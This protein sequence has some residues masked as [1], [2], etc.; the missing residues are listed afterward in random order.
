MDYPKLRL[1]EAF[2][3]Q[4]N[5]ICLRDTES[6]SDKIL[7]VP[8]NIFFI[9]TLFDGQHSIKDIQEEYTRRYG[10][11]LFGSKVREIIEQ[12]DNCLFLESERFK[13]ARKRAIAEFKMSK[14]RSA[15]HAGS[16]YESERETLL[17]QLESFFSLPDGPGIPGS[18]SRSGRLKGLIA[19]HIDLR[20]GGPCFAWSYAEAARESSAH[21]F[22]IL[23]ISHTDTQKRFVLTAKD[24]ETPLGRI[25]TD[26]DFIESLASKCS[27]D[28]FT[29][30][31]VHRSEHSIEFQLLFLQYLF[32]DH[33]DIKIVPILCSSLQPIMDAEASPIKN[34]EVGDFIEALKAVIEE[35]NGDVCCIAGVDLSHVGQ[36]FGQMINISPSFISEIEKEDRRMLEYVLDLDAEG[37]F[38]F[39]RNEQDRRNVCG[40]PAI[41]AL[42][43]VVEA[44]SSKLLKYDRAVDYNTQSLVTFAGAALYADNS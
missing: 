13:E 25:E 21:T 31:F 12:L 3:V 38:Q 36:R 16:A 43:N 1:I 5:H 19:P 28:F 24:F 20:F 11:L 26:K 8:H 44:N 2:P 6:Y 35:L 39:I 7:L 42:L 32:T 4:N 9:C 23:G 41:Y 33:R 27:G 10:D 14:V 15:T 18:E 37:F 29:D 22:V 34:P 17:K 40:V 30:E